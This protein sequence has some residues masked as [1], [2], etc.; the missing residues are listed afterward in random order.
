MSLLFVDDNMPEV[1]PRGK[2]YVITRY[3]HVAGGPSL[4]ALQLDPRQFTLLS[5]AKL[6]A[7]R[8][9][10][11]LSPR[12]LLAYTPRAEQQPDVLA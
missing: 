11:R 12:V 2:W 1:P 10:W 3:S 9:D 6:A 7:S 5:L 8:I 4:P